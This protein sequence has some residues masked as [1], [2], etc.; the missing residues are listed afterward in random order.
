MNTFLTK[1]ITGT[2]RLISALYKRSAYPYAEREWERKGANMT[3]YKSSKDEVSLT[4]LKYWILY[5]G[6]WS[7]HMWLWDHTLS[8]GGL[9]PRLLGSTELSIVWRT[10]SWRNTKQW[11]WPGTCLVWYYSYHVTMV[12]GTKMWRMW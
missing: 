3:T 4:I 6:I 8:G 12:I 11:R 2:V 1:V 5:L 10:A 9:T 7:S